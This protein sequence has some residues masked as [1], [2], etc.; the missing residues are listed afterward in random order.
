MADQD[1]R[2]KEDEGKVKEG[3]L[4]RLTDGEIEL[5]KTVFRST[6]PYHNVWIHCDSYLPF[7]LQGAHTAMSPN[8]D[9]YFRPPLYRKDYSLVV[10]DLQHLFIH[11][12]SHVWQ[13]EQGMN[14]FARGIVSG[15]VSYRY[16]LD[17]RRLC[18]YRMEQQAQII[19]D[20]FTLDKYGY[21]LWSRLRQGKNPLI[22]CDDNAPEIIIRQKYKDCL[23]GFPW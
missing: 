5:A 18:E 1:T 14:V 19:A 20:R 4:R 23:R 12:M 7:G 11:E 2:D 17:G 16:S 15:L 3:T 22:T 6:I 8:G 13:H 10:D 21:Y 9:I